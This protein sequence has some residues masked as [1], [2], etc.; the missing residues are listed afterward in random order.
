MTAGSVVVWLTEGTWPSVVDAA[1]AAAPAEAT[2]VLLHVV[3][4]RLEE[5]LP[6]RSR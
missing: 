4:T 5:A 2:V 1:A 6:P 3:D